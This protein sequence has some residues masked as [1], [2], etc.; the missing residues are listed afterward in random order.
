MRLILADDH[1]I[2]RQGLRA[3]FERTGT[4]EIV[5]EAENGEQA[6]AMTQALNPEALILDITMPLLNGIQVIQQIHASYPEIKLIVLSMHSERDIVIEALKAGCH[7]FLLKTTDFQNIIKALEAVMRGD[8]YFSPE[9]TKLLVNEV[10]NSKSDQETRDIT[11]LSAR[12][13]QVLQLTAEGFSVKEIA[14]R[15][16]LSNKTIDSTRRRVMHKLDEQTIAGL[17]R[18]AIREGLASME[19]KT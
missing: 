19:C 8:R 10:F 13:H 6:V 5:G 12:E 9:I 1:N 2:M 4:A 16:H 17:T 18:I 14:L 3:Q 7:G 15:L 11:T